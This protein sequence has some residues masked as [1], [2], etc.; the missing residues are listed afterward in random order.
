MSGRPAGER[1]RCYAVLDR[2]GDLI[3]LHQEMRFGGIPLA[4]PE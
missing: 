2:N 1:S 4:K 3:V